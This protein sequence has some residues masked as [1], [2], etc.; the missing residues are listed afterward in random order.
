MIK[1][2]NLK[3]LYPLSP[4]QE[5]MLYQ[6]LLHPDAPVYHEQ[7]LYRLR[8]ALRVD[9]LEQ[10]WER[11]FQRHDIL[12]VQ[13]IAEKVS[14]PLQAV[15][16]QRVGEFHYND[17][18]EASPDF[19]EELIRQAQTEDRQRSFD[20]QREPLMRMR[21]L[22]LSDDR[23]ALLW[24]LHH[25]LMDGW[26]LGL[27]L[28][29]FTLI[30]DALR[31]GR[32]V[33]LPAPPP[34]SRY[35]QWLERQ[36][37]IRA[38]DYWRAQLQDSHQAAQIPRQQT[39]APASAGKR[40]L[41]HT[42]PAPLSERVRQA[43]ADWG[44]TPG[45]LL[46]AAWGALLARYND[47]DDVAFGT[48][49][50]GRP[51]ELPGAMEMVGVFINTLPLRL[52]IGP[53][54]TLREL[55]KTT[56]MRLLEAESRQYLPLSDIQSLCPLGKDLIT[57]LF[58]FENYPAPAHPDGAFRDAIQ[59]ESIS[60][61]EDIPYDFGV[62]ATPEH[63]PEGATLVMRYL[64]NPAQFESAFVERLSGHYERLLRQGLGAAGNIRPI[65]LQQIDLLDN[66]E[67]DRLHAFRGEDA[68]LPSCDSYLDLFEQAVAA[69][70][71]SIAV[72]D[73]A[74]RISYRELD[75]RVNALAA[76]LQK[77]YDVGVED[78]IGVVLP[79]SA[80]LLI[81]ELAA[82]KAGAAFVPV[83]P[84]YPPER[85][86]RTFQQAQCK[87]VI[88]DAAEAAL[89]REHSQIPFLNLD[90]VDPHSRRAQ[91]PERACG[92]RSLAYVIFTS[93]STGEPKGVMLEHVGL[94]NLIQW[95]RRQFNIQAGSR[96]TLL[97]SPAFD[98]SVWESL[99]S[100]C[101]GATIVI[102][103]DALRRD[104]GPL[105]EFLH[106]QRIDISFLPPA[107]CEEA[108]VNYPHLLQNIVLQS[109]GDTLKGIRNGG[110][111]DRIKVS[112]NYGPSE[113][114][115]CAA[116]CYLA[117]QEP[118][119]Y[120]IGK[121]I[122]NAEVLI[123]D[124]QRRLAPLGA[125]GE[126]A[127]S[128][129]SLARGYWGRADL[130]AAHF[131]AHPLRPGERVYLTGDKG[132]WREDG[133]LDF[134]G[135]IDDQLSV[136][137]HRVEPA[138]IEH[139]LSR[140]ERVR[141][142]AVAA[143]RGADGHTLLAAFVTPRSADDSPLDLNDI[144]QWLARRAPA[145][146]TPAILR[147]RDS[148]PLNANGKLDRQAIRR[149]AEQLRAEAPYEAPQTDTEKL[150]AD[151]WSQV[152]DHRPIGRNDH[153]LELGGH[154]LSATRALSQLR[155]R[156]RRDLSLALLFDKPVL[157]DLA[158]AIDAPGAAAPSAPES[159]IRRAD[160]SRYA[161]AAHRS[162]IQNPETQNPAAAE[163]S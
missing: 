45:A 17:L 38:R 43:A 88:G 60:K 82:G 152:L 67:R 8:G 131:V 39:L 19:Q 124:S 71:D 40:T 79:R 114:S 101:A 93:G 113:F 36:D 81:A 12:R 78:R 30:Y 20:L 159:G 111:S 149:E 76:L 109:G 106:E 16:H 148:L 14:R 37:Q 42:L 99:P 89:W 54:D 129:P 126:I 85:R 162:E 5:G 77:R 123:L 121:P 47:C 117:P 25:I 141:A 32:P 6:S 2:E 120:P 29:D 75:E 24:S 110:A 22:Q 28:R 108:C 102:T 91:A 105:C 134:L 41:T 151:I 150:V 97:A 59:V 9:L 55:A 96:T 136:R 80:A 46:Q 56:Q 68:P 50:S 18:R 92:L 35:I 52:R 70:P 27:L 4:M 84:D 132:R 66:A 163:S 133:N 112:N 116:S 147:E 142:A 145:Y 139:L 21:L 10:A 156:L 7:A 137:G 62:T 58:A 15:L 130:T 53:D 157:K 63:G 57:H 69:A 119:P 11:L 138:E 65:A 34:Y 104:V 140:H 146:M 83:D 122:A 125:A 33:D 160:R 158:A 154:S 135:R 44:L 98:A 13:F 95:S 153:F 155:G 72:E 127:L 115:V 128:G 74:R 107:L 61:H 143:T 86:L 144:R 64:Y 94:I 103:P 31:E 118:S 49:V 100:L 87:L 3:D 51:A 23:F 90:A 73:G 161:V 48:L 26:C 1:K